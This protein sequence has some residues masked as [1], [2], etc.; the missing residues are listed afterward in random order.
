M[1]DPIVIVGASHA[2]V[3]LAQSLRTEGCDVPIRLFSD[4]PFLPYHRP[5]LSKAYQIDPEA[6]VMALRPESFF[7][8]S[9]V[10]LRRATRVTAIDRAARTVTAGGE[11]FDYGT[12]VLAT[13]AVPRRL[14]IESDRVLYLRDRA[15][16]DGIRA[17]LRT[18]QRMIVIGGGFI[19]LEVAA[20]AAKL[21]LSVTV[22]EAQPRLLARVAPPELSAHVA[23]QHK[24]AGVGIR[25]GAGVADV[26]ES[27]GEVQV[28]LTDG[29]TL[30]ADVVLVGI[31]S[32]PNTGLAEA[33]G[34]D[35]G[36]QG[37]VVDAHLRTSDPNVYAIGD[38]V[39]FPCVQSGQMERLE[40]VQ[41]A[42]DQARS[43]AATLI[44]A[45]APYTALPW[46]WTDQYDMKIQMAGL[47]GAG[48]TTILR[49][50]PDSGAFSVLSFEGDRLRA[51]YS[52]NAAADHM[53]ARKLIAGNVR[54]DPE[55]GRDT[56]IALKT[57]LN[58]NTPM[59]AATRAAE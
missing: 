40:S 56:E 26:T 38:C 47:P 35:A 36:P 59:P 8:T 48:S 29:T 33:A 27:G 20:I 53:A 39:S 10:D 17:H 57:H 46:F 55:A 2:G 6:R 23:H 30:A 25:T 12:L 14:E 44:G 15:D 3:Q 42:A 51:A 19:G 28:T 21:G 9:S 58:T 43:L 1:T 13:G 49:G 37:I 4:E 41:N 5:P 24:A 16:A 54:F 11:T 31:G 18:A 32:L 34:I 45:P 50:T 52:V 22:I 7:E